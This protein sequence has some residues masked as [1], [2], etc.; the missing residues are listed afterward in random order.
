MTRS[1]LAAIAATLA[2]MAIG[3][4]ADVNDPPAFDPRSFQISQREASKQLSTND[5]RPLPTTLPDLPKNSARMNQNNSTTQPSSI[6][7]GFDAGSPV[8]RLSLREMIQ[9]TVANNL[10]VK[11]A[12]YDPAIEGTR[13][14]ENEAK[15]DP[16]FFANTQFEH[17]DNLTSGNFVS[18]PNTG[19]TNIVTFSKADIYSAE[20]GLKQNLESGGQA[21][22][23]YST[24]YNDLD[25]QQSSLNP[26]WENNLELQITQPILRNFGTDINRANITISKN[27]QRISLLDFRKSLEEQIANTETAYWSLVDAVEEVRIA[28]ELLGRTTRMVEILNARINQDVTIVQVSQARASEESRKAALVRARA[29]V[30]DLSDQLKRLMNDPDMPVSSASII[31][32]STEPMMDPIKFNL[33]EQ[34][35]TG[36]E[37]RFELGQQM[38]RIDSASVASKV[39]K[40]G[41]LPQLNLIGS[42]GFQGL[43]N[44]IGGAAD[45]QLDANHIS[46]SLG[47]QLEIPIGNREARAVWQRA[48]LQRQQA[49]EQYRSL[50]EQV[51]LDVKT[52]AREVE[53]TW[54]EMISTRLARYAADQSL[55]AIQQREDAK[56]PLTPTFVQLKLDTQ[57][58]LAS[59]KSSEAQAI[60]NYN[61][62]LS[63]LERAKGTLLRYNNVLLEEDKTPI[64]VSK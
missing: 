36:L 17:R 52:A 33:E 45:K 55:S 5:K 39:A 34:I 9:R 30:G 24:A 23:K 6:P 51:S 7:P 14:V 16:A 54:N 29:R 49:I 18:N 12:G 44:S 2:A 41:L 60:S 22:L 25:P 26:Y 19:Q 35:A 43:D 64:G 10:D 61:N 59:A 46:Y 48:L 42:G 57:E 40:N 21:Q 4:C 20:T 31:L 50:I 38:L 1:N 27:N 13:V 15:F 32:P 56:E 37:N 53:T 63:K 47:V 8:T 58:R 28:E 3:G 11:V 62:G